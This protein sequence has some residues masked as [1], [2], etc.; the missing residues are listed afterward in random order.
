[1]VKNHE[2]KVEVSA[3]FFDGRS[4]KAQAVTL[5]LSHGCVAVHDDQGILILEQGVA[6]C[7]LA[8]PL[9][10][11]K[12][13]LKTSATAHCLLEPDSAAALAHFFPTRK[14]LLLVD[15]FE[16]RWGLVTVALVGCLLFVWFFIATGIPFLAR[17]AAYAMPSQAMT[18][19]GSQTLAVLDE[20]FFSPSAL[21]LEQQHQTHS[22]FQQ[23]C[24][25]LAVP[26]CQLELRQG[27]ELGANAFALPS[28]QV[29]MTD[30]LVILSQ[31]QGDEGLQGVI[32]HELGHV[33]NRHAL[34]HVIQHS[35]IF[36]L[37]STLTGDMGS[38]T[39]VAASLPMVLAE[40]RYSRSF[41]D[42]ADAF[43]CSYFLDQGKSCA[44]YGELLMLATKGRNSDGLSRY[45]A[46]HPPTSQ[47]LEAFHALHNST[48]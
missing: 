11:A 25:Q 34:R 37:I 29:V 17:Q 23:V 35:G 9:G 10:S 46:S 19:L 2:E 4:S 16:R 3:L 36:L 44:A 31:G 47:R 14:G 1:M 26:S 21:P 20:Q 15:F 13:E 27:N 12:V 22:L 7:H 43:A 5:T 40:S 30:E 38:L 41:E 18:L 8:P 45:F 24:Q 32:A 28:G 48:L 39:S 33:T 42:E 6:L